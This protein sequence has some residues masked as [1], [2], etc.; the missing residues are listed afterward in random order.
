ME[1]TFFNRIPLN[2]SGGFFVYRATEGEEL[3]FVDQNVLN[4]Y[5]FQSMDEFRAYTGNS[6]RGMVYPEDLERVESEIYAQTIKSGERHDYVHYRIQTKQGT[7]RYVEDF[8]HL[9]YGSDNES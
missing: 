4:L 5:G 7:I 3:C 2:L 1:Q 6:F 9:V 8:G